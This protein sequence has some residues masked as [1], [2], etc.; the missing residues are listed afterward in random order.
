MI[1]SDGKDQTECENPMTENNS[2]QETMG[3]TLNED[4]ESPMSQHVVRVNNEV[5]EGPE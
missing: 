2:A 4:S 1:G 5:G 3:G